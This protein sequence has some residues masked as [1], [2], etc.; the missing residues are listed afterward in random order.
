MPMDE[1]QNNQTTEYVPV[2]VFKTTSNFTIDKLTLWNPYED[3]EPSCIKEQIKKIFEETAETYAAWQIWEDEDEYG[4]TR[5]YFTRLYILDK[6]ADVIQAA[7]NTAYCIGFSH[8][9]IERAMQDC[10][11]RNHALGRC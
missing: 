6:L 10:Q 7:M 9:D 5:L 2:K 4:R 11:Q 8:Y 1:K 3:D